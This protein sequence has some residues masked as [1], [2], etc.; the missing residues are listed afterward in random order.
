MSLP[1]NLIANST[2][3]VAFL[4]VFTLAS[5]CSGLSICSNRAA[6]WISPN[7]PL[8]FTFP[9]TFFNPPTS[10]A[11]FFISPNPFCT[12]SNWDRTSSKDCPI[13]SFNVF[14]SFSSTMI[15]I[16]SNRFSVDFTRMSC[17]RFIASNFSRCISLLV[18]KLR[19]N[20]VCICWV[21][22]L[23]AWF[24]SVRSSRMLRPN[25]SRFSFISWRRRFSNCS[26]CLR[27]LF[28][29]T[30][31]K[32][33]IKRIRMIVSRISSINVVILSKSSEK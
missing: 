14:C 27:L 30:T 23:N 9:N 17:W 11:K 8:V 24:S 12:F 7:V 20:V 25:S 22:R 4:R 2:N 33:V 13:R 16:S 28:N 10:S 21:E 15:R 19:C 31:N 29:R 5:Y 32:L 6:N 18:I 3:S 26:V 1:G